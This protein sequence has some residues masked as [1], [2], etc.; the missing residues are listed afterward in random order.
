MKC[1]DPPPC[2]WTR[3]WTTRDGRYLLRLTISTGLPE[4]AIDRAPWTKTATC[5]T[6][7][8]AI[9]DRAEAIAEFVRRVS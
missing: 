3:R 7:V 6:Q 8:A 9:D 4:F 5:W 1:L 2:R